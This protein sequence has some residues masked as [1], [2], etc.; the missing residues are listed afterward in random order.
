MQTNVIN[1]YQ[2]DAGPAAWDDGT[3]ILYY[4]LAGPTSFGVVPSISGYPTVG[5]RDLFSPFFPAVLNRLQ[6]RRTLPPA[7][8]PGQLSRCARAA[9]PLPIIRGMNPPP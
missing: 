8:C 4:G 9:P 5:G 7:G 3:V 1:R 2:S 6:G